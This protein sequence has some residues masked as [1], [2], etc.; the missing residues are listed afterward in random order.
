MSKVNDPR[1]T[2]ALNALTWMQLE[3][4]AKSLLAGRMEYF[5]LDVRTSPFNMIWTPETAHIMVWVEAGLDEDHHIHVD[6]MTRQGP[7][8]WGRM[9]GATGRFGSRQNVLL[10]SI[11]LTRFIYGWPAQE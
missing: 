5:L 4:Y 6:Q 1:L 9:P 10:A 2:T 11:K 8:K 7:G 3:E